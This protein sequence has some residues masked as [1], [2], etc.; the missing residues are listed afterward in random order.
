MLLQP[1][2]MKTGLELANTVACPTLSSIDL[3]DGE[4]GVFSTSQIASWAGPLIG[5]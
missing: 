5:I 1:I 3:N 2:A 4:Y